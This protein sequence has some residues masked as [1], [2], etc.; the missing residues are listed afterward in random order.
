MYVYIYV[1]VCVYVCVNVCTYA[2]VVVRSS[3]Q[4]RWPFCA[5]QA[6]LTH[7]QSLLFSFGASLRLFPSVFQPQMC[8]CN[9][10]SDSVCMSRCVRM[11][12][13]V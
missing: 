9:L 3:E 1:C 13:Y 7:F 2:P 8:L 10:G 11:K 12:V 5:I 4:L 6:A